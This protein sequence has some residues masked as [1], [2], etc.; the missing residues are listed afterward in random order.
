MPI[1]LLF[2]FLLCFFPAVG[3]A[4]I[5]PQLVELAKKEGELVFYSSSNTEEVRDLIEGFK[6][7]YPF[8]KASFYRTGD[9][10]LL[11]RVRT[12]AQAG[13]FLWD[14]VDLTTYP[15]YWLAK[16]GYFAKYLPPERAFLRKGHAD[17]QGLWNPIHSNVHALIY[18]TKL[19]LKGSIPKTHEDL[20][21]PRWTG[22]ICMDTKAY[23][24]FAN[25]LYVMGEERGKAFMKRLGE[26]KIMFRTG[27]TLNTQLVAAGET[28]LGVAL[29]L[30]R[31]KD[32][33]EKGAPIDWVL[34]EP[35]VANLHPVSLSAKAPHPNAGKLFIRYLLSPEIQEYFA[36]GGQL[37]SRND[38]APG[39]KDLLRGVEPYPSQAKL[40]ERLN[41]YVELYRK[42]LQVS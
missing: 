32:M 28:A 14:V 22:K 19:V 39:I 5:D 6:R 35:A 12:E 24:W 33:K 13:R 29:Y 17:E 15:G 1:L 27:R 18:N 9:E 7:K 3:L 40:A 30:H 36:R 11:S 8:I 4:Q 42:F 37:P 26:Q 20:L 38:V 41:E 34:L 21:D 23:E 2:F 16:E 31:A 25:L 10:A